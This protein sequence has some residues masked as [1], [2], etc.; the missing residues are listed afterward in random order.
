M[1]GLFAYTRVIPA[2]ANS[3]LA[4][5]GKFVALRS[6]TAEVTVTLRK[7]QVDD[8]SGESYSL[9]MIAK[10]K[11]EHTEPFDAVDIKND[12]GGIVTV[13]VIIGFGNFDFP[14]V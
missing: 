9:P 5:N 1:G 13:Q 11:W 8:Q 7:N 6:A 3:A 14:P 2:G 10:E 4:V 12:T